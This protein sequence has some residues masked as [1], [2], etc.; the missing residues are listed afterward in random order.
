MAEWERA[1][2]LHARPYS[3][4]SLMLDMFF[5]QSGRLTILAKGARRKRSPLKGVLQPFTPLLAR[6]HGKGSLKTLLTAEA[7]SLSLPLTGNGL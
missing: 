6:Y 5:E 4:T 7:V 1:F 2:V 3:E